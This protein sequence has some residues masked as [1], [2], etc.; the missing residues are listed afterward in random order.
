MPVA[1]LPGTVVAGLAE[2][3]FLLARTLSSCSILRCSCETR[4]L[5][6]FHGDIV[7]WSLR[8]EQYP[9]SQWGQGTNETNEET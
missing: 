6:G 2:M 4:R 7:P 5:V 1:D 3:G 8:V 9:A